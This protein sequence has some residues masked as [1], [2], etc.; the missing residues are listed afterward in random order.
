MQ[1][2]KDRMVDLVI[3]K[4]LKKLRD[5]AEL[6]QGEAADHLG[7]SSANISDVEK[8]LTSVRASYLKELLEFYD[9]PKMSSFML[10]VEEYLVNQ[11]EPSIL[12]GIANTL[13][14]L[15]ESGATIV[16][17]TSK[18]SWRQS[19]LLD[20]LEYSLGYYEQ[21]YKKEEA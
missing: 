1:T 17:D 21:H 18:D 2:G 15:K 13:L 9:G 11:D 7:V 5:T 10:E 4:L 19:Q 6:T 16:L 20:I 14:K 12:R 3:G 8:G